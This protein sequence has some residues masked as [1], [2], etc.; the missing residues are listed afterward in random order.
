MRM[1]GTVITFMHRRKQHC[2][3]FLRTRQWQAPA[4]WLGIRASGS[5]SENSRGG[6]FQ[7]CVGL[8]GRSS[9]YKSAKK[10]KILFW[11]YKPDFKLTT[12]IA[13]IFD[14]FGHIRL[15]MK[16]QHPLIDN[17]LSQFTHLM[18]V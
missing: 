15:F 8:Y 11:A 6:Y 12:S 18:D 5:D 13:R 16:L 7:A 4:V 14:Q 17:T 3:V 1:M 9:Q 10:A 2:S